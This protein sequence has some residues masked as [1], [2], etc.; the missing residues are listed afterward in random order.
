MQFYASHDFDV[1]NFP[2]EQKPVENNI[3]KDNLSEK[4]LELLKDLIINESE[5]RHEWH[6]PVDPI[7]VLQSPDRLHRID[8]PSLAPPA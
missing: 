7:F 8:I 3:L 2:K 1:N 5:L 4:D 6:V